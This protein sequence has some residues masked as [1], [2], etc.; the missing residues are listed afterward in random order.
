MAKISK[1]FQLNLS[2]LPEYQSYIWLKS[3]KSINT[4]K[5]TLININTGEIVLRRIQF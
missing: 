5:F 4:G 2:F 1:I 3:T